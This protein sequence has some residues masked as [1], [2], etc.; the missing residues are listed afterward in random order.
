MVYNEHIFK[1]GYE[2]INL[3]EKLDRSFTG[4]MLNSMD[5]KNEVV[6]VGR[7]KLQSGSVLLCTIIL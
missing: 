6:F 2:N 5:D 4:F 3:K 7:D 1:K